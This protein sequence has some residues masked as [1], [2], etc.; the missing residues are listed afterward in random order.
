MRMQLKQPNVFA[1]LLHQREDVVPFCSV[2]PAEADRVR[3]MFA[4]NGLSVEIKRFATEE[5]LDLAE[6]DP[7][8][9]APLHATTVT[10][11]EHQLG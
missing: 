5:Y 4:L 6:Q 11:F 9:Y 2:E 10:S 3:E 7:R 1:V 8:H